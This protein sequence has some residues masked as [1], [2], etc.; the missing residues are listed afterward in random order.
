MR[1]LSRRFSGLYIS[2]NPQLRMLRTHPPL[3]RTQHHTV[4][5]MLSQPH[6][7]SS[8]L[9]QNMFHSM[10]QV[11]GCQE[12]IEMPRFVSFAMFML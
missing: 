6:T 10:H 3:F 5:T 1:Y 2:V 7:H 8:P 12:R 4:M 11:L 9:Q